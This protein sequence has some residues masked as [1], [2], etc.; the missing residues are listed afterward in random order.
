MRLVWDMGC[1]CGLA[2]SNIQRSFNLGISMPWHSLAMAKKSITRRRK[3]SLSRN[4]VLAIEGAAPE[5]LRLV[6]G[7]A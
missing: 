3:S 2:A 5:A 4:R 6:L 1:L 7:A